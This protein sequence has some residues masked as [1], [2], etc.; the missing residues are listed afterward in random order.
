MFNKQVR[1]SLVLFILVL[2][3]GCGGSSHHSG[4]GSKVNPEGIYSISGNASLGDNPLEGV[5]VTLSGAGSGT[6]TTDANGN[7]SF[8][9]LPD[10]SYTLTPSMSGYVF[11]P[12]SKAVT[13][14]GS[15]VDSVN[16]HATADQN[17]LHNI[18]GTVTL[19]RMYLMRGVMMTLS[20][21]NSGTT[22]T[23][24]NGRYTFS[25]LACGDYT[26]T[27]GIVGYVFDPAQSAQT[28][29]GAD[30]QNAD[31]AASAGVVNYRI[32]DL[33]IAGGGFF[34]LSYGI[35]NC[36]QVVG[37]AGALT[38]PLETHAFILSDGI[39]ADLGTFGGV[40][41]SAR[42]IN[43]MGQVIGG[44]DTSDRK[45]H[46]FLYCI[47]GT[48][49]DLGTLGGDES[50]AYAVNNK[51]EVVGEADNAARNFRAFAYSNGTMIDLGT[52]GGDN[53]SAYAVNDKSQIAGEADT[54]DRLSHAFLYSAGTMTDLGTLGGR[55]STAWGI[56]DYS[57]VVGNSGI[58]DGGYAH[59]A[60]VYSGGQMMDIGTL[61]GYTAWA[62]DINNRGQIVG[63]SMLSNGI[64][65][66]FIFA[67]TTMTDLNSFLPPDSG[68]QLINASAIND[69]GQITGWGMINGEE[70][71]FLLTPIP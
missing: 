5:T 20:G 70:H 53:S 1:V 28:I 41:S 55:W 48:M 12:A 66:A 2:L 39:F 36:S 19:N 56:N 24:E 47:G 69:N 40:D 9:D 31:F 35:N 25:N 14:Q 15:N 68:W 3:V 7:Y 50:C 64:V 33:G 45:T 54:P 71:S 21:A 44:A 8:T 42:G 67:G 4:S 51:G 17:V 29:N 26:V 43:D 65:H 6:V 18:S 10:G 58:D 46:A 60:F 59:H 52:L 34:N 23:D 30:I 11:T 37:E 27:P 49:T 16:F 22:M 61:G 38:V 32:D 13:I 57:Q 62:L 63:N